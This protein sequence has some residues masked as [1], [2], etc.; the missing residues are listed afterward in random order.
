MIRLETIARDGPSARDDI[1]IPDDP[2]ESPLYE[3]IIDAEQRV[4][5]L[6]DA[7]LVA[8]YYLLDEQWPEIYV[9]GL[10]DYSTVISELR[11]RDYD[12]AIIDG[13]G[14]VTNEDGNVVRPVET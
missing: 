10:A 1:D 8:Q 12:T 7:E 2:A 5:E 6:D 9:Q 13:S 4:G 14:V 11:R 3:S